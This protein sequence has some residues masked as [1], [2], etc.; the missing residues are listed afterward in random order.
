MSSFLASMSTAMTVV[1]PASAAPAMAA[2]PTPPQP[3]TATDSPRVTLPVLMAAPMPAITPQPSSP[4]AAG[5]ASGSTLVHWPAATRVFSMNAPMP[6]AGREFGAVLQRHFLGGVVGVEAVLRLASAA[7]PAFA[8]DSPP[9]QHHTVARRHFGDIGAHRADHAG[10]LMAQQE[11]EIVAD[12]A[13]LVVQVGVADPAG[14]D[15]H[16]GLAGAGIRH[17]DGFQ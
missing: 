7:G 12:G 9:V 15:V 10:G 4:M 1:A 6:S 2:M 8:A 16:Q 14:K 11:R 13:L 17:Q 5:S 3:M